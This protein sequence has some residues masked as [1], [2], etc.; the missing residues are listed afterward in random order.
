MPTAFIS[1]TR[2]GRTGQPL[3][4]QVE[5]ARTGGVAQVVGRQH[6]AHTQVEELPDEPQI[7]FERPGVLQ[8]E[9]DRDP[10]VPVHPVDGFDRVAEHQVL[11][12]CHAGA[13]RRKQRADL[14]GAVRR[15]A[16]VDRRERPTGPLV[17]AQLTEPRPG[18]QRQARVLLPQQ[19]VA[20]HVPNGTARRCAPPVR[21]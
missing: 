2:P 3:V 15:V 14:V 11:L 9:R 6:R 16:D 13:K 19:P 12:E 5:A 10:T 1:R 18:R 8:V 21:R 20:R 7:P 4:D 17:A